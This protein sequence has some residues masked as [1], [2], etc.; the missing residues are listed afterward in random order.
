[1]SGWPTELADVPEVLPVTPRLP[2]Q[3]LT[4]FADIWLD[5]FFTDMAVV[6]RIREAQR[7]VDRCAGVVREVQAELGKRDATV[8]P[9]LQ[10]IERE[11]RDLLTPPL[12]P[13]GSA[14]GQA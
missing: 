12:P 6:A 11:R 9:R 8:Q 3:G 5:N 4:R 7:S 14:G 10:P 1:M 13:A 2:V